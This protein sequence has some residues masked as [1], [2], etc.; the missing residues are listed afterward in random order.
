MRTQMQNA[1]TPWW[2]AASVAAACAVLLGGCTSMPWD[3]TPF[4]SS[5][6]TRTDNVPAMVVPAGF[7]RVNQ[8]DTVGGVASAF[9]QRA[10]DIA[11]WNGLAPNTMLTPGQVLRV[12]R[13]SANGYA[14]STPQGNGYAG[15][16]ANGYAATPSGNGYATA[17]SGNGYANSANNGSNFA[18]GAAIATGP[19]G[20]DTAAVQPGVLMWPLRGPVLK[21]FVPG[22]SKGIVIGGHAGDP[23][24][25][26]ASGR[27]VYA[28]TGIEAYG[29]LII[30]KHDDS[31]ITAYGQ[32]STLLVKEGDAV[33]QG[34]PIG[35]VGVDSRG[36]ASIQFEVRKDGH[37]VDPVAWLPR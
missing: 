6:P 22:Q 10:Q 34:Q 31:L 2:G 9:G 21:T 7:Y 28:G 33:T 5:A 15:G 26:A 20:T 13:P 25:A 18:N 23:V 37:P 11:S 29:P 12:A 4:Y 36:V 35:A 14:S 19:G 3:S 17:P 24:K 30:I 27:V 16:N 1:G 8:G 32:N